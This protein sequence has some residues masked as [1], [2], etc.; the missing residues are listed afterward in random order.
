MNQANSELTNLTFTFYNMDIIWTKNGSTD[1]D[2]CQKYFIDICVL[3]MH[4]S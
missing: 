4:I 1:L 3:V 2:I